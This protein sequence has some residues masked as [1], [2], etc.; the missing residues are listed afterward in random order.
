MTSLHGPSPRL[1]IVTSAI[2]ASSE[3]IV[4]DNRY[5]ISVKKY[6]WKPYIPLCYSLLPLQGHNTY[7]SGVMVIVVGNGH[8]DTSSNPG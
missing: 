5:C 1:L 4:T 8:V 3:S 2:N 7:K 6:H